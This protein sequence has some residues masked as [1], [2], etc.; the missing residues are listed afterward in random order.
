MSKI[1]NYSNRKAS[2]V[3]HELTQ[4]T[5]D[6]ILGARSHF[7]QVVLR[8]NN[9]AL[10]ADVPF[11]AYVVE[12]EGEV[13]ILPAEKGAPSGIFIVGSGDIRSISDGKTK[14]IKMRGSK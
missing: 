13:S 8:R 11:F 12:K 14:I 6:T 4:Q 3:K 10:P 9:T 2:N 1:V 5:A 7:S